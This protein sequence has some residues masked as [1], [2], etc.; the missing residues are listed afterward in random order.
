[1]TTRGAHAAPGGRSTV[2]PDEIARF[3]RMA[4][5]WWDPN[6]DFRPL[7]GLNPLRV[8]FVTNWILRHSGRDSAASPP[9]AGL[10]VLDIGCGGGLLAE[11]VARQ[12]ARVTGI[13]ASRE[14]IGVASVHRDR[15]GLAITY[16][17]A[18]PEELAVEGL[19]YDVVLAME[20][21]EHVAD[22]PAF[23]A[24]LV[25]LIRP[26]GLLVMSTLNR[27][28]KSLLLAKIAAE[29]VLRWVP[30]GTH[31]WRKFIR[32]SMLAFH[33]RHA[34]L[35]VVDAKGLTY[36]PLTD[37]WAMGRD[38]SVNYFLVAVKP[39]PEDPGQS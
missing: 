8:E 5:S 22:V 39:G 18:S 17:T 9:L 27:T 25:D 23:V 12:G 3:A 31:D 2:S 13:D 34:G 1:M 4:D 20:V 33:L 26:G 21:V 37:G 24:A 32:P 16:R 30:A 10:D 7:H 11:P 28:L 38:L 14:A 6:G 19:S 35:D 15:E 36:D 29:Y